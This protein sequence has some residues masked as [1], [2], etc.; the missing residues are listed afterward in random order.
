MKDKTAQPGRVAIVSHAHPSLSKGGAE[1]SAYSL[2][3]GLRAL[4]AD[5]IFVAACPY[6][7]CGRLI[8]GSAHEHAIYYDPQAYEH[9]YHLALPEAAQQLASLLDAQDVQVVNFHHFL[10]YGLEVL[11]RVRRPARQL[12][13]TLH[14]YLA[15]CHNHG[16]MISPSR[17]RLCEGSAPDVCT[18]CFPDHIPEQFAMRRE[19]F[20]RAFEAVDH[21]VSPS[22]FLVNRMIAWGLPASLLSVVENGLVRRPERRGRL[23]HQHGE[24]WVFGFFGQINPFKGIDVLLRAVTM[25]AEDSALAKSV[26]VRIYGNFIGQT[27]KFVQSVHETVSRCP[28]LSYGGPY[29]NASVAN[30]MAAC[31]YVV[32]P[33]LWWENSPVVI[34]EAF[35]VGRPVICSGIGG[36]AEKVDNGV[37]GLHFA[38]GDHRDLA[39]AMRMA[40]SQNMFDQ[41]RDNL[42]SVH[43]HVGM[44]R[45]YLRVFGQQDLKMPCKRP[46]SGMPMNPANL[47]QRSR[48]SAARRREQKK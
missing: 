13:L 24:P 31:D 14:E 10:Q 45:D 48:R 46:Q 26:Q 38:T 11:E 36:M 41:L 39:R 9:F 23:P 16:Q 25:I 8:L 47:P 6:S 29:E 18:V 27:Q 28:L 42:P 30:L 43:D 15:I 12:V 4:G 7:D 19:S 37:N 40:A 2:Y 21:F 1:I 44:A 3:Q 5:A 34:Q 32:V 17:N 35:A 33:S 20:L 22:Q